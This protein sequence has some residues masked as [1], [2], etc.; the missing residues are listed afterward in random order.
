MT[1]DRK[2]SR[3]LN[4]ASVIYNKQGFKWTRQR[5][6]AAFLGAA[7]S[8]DN[9]FAAAQLKTTRTRIATFCTQSW[10]KHI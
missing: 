1:A 3:L 8:A 4:T 6:R 9:A 7:L 10:A 2:N 5:A